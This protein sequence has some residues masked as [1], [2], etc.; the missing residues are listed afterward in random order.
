MST[1]SA[2]CPR[3]DTYVPSLIP[4]NFSELPPLLPI[5]DKELERLSLTHPSYIIHTKGLILDSDDPLAPE[6]ASWKALECKGDAA[7]AHYLYEASNHYWSNA[8]ASALSSIRQQFLTNRLFATISRHYGFH[9]RVL[10]SPHENMQALRNNESVLADS[11][12]AYVGALA[13]EAARTR[14]QPRLSDWFSCFFSERVFPTLREVGLAREENLR[15]R[16]IATTEKKALGRE[17]QLNCAAEKQLGKRDADAMSGKDDLGLPK[18]DSSKR[19]CGEG[20]KEVS[21]LEFYPPLR[22]ADSDLSRF[23]SDVKAHPPRPKK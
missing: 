12:E 7:L 10:I 16:R 18:P 5:D 19:Q 11:F 20:S 4:I 14:Q 8:S 23:F 1:Y 2:P 17:K 15:K 13:T 21:S 3:Y 6:L 9:H 22:H